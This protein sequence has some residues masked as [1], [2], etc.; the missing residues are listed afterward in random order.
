MSQPTS[1]LSSYL[2]RAYADLPAFKDIFD[3]EGFYL[4]FL[5]LV[6]M[7]VLVAVVASRFVV[8]READI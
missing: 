4:A 1:K 3:E 5:G 6:L 7:S 8:L 2:S